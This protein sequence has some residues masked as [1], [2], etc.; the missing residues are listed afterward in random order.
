MRKTFKSL[1]VATAIAMA[2]FAYADTAPVGSTLVPQASN[3]AD[4]SGK[5]V[6]QQFLWNKCIHCFH[7]DPLVDEWE[8]KNADYITF[9][10][11]PVGWGKSNLDDGAYY[12]YAK[13]LK[14]TGKATDE[15]LSKINADLFNLVFVK[16]QELNATNAF[17]IFQK[18]GIDSPESLEKL[19]NSFVASSE[20]NKSQKLT[21]DYGV[22]GVPVFVVAG[23]YMVSFS[24]IG[25]DAT[26]EK[27]FSVIDRIAKSEHDATLK[28][29][30]S[31]K[32]D[33]KIDPNVSSKQLDSKPVE[34]IK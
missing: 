11:I 29:S 13:V 15:D 31:P 26:P 5:V 21:K 32:S 1:F 8:K 34:S 27:L 28:V 4:E 9:E 33:V 17:P 20:R 6:V 24:T 7:L 22:N 2:S 14:K 19:M 25:D 3:Y 16:K 10:R 30:D 23:K 18:Y 12:N